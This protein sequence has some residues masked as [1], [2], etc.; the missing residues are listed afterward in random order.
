MSARQSFEAEEAVMVFSW[1]LVTEKETASEK[2][3][4]SQGDRGL[5]RNDTTYVNK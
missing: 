3:A 4:A 1:V 2:N 5:K